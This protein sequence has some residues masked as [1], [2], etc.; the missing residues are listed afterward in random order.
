MI[1]I[2][3]LIIDINFQF[4]KFIN[5]FSFLNYKTDQWKYKYKEAWSE[6]RLYIFGSSFAPN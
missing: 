4:K 5:Y 1:I 6:I 3:T 2:K